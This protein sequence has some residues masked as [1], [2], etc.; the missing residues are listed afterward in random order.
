MNLGMPAKL[1]LAEFEAA[2]TSEFQMDT[3]PEIA[4]GDVPL[5]GAPI[6]STTMLTLTLTQ[7]K[8]K[9]MNSMQEC[10]SL[11]FKAPNDAP[12][13]QALYRLHHPVIGSADIFLVP[14]KKTDEGLFYEAVFN[15][16]IA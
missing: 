10:F 6:G 11:V 3:N 8:V 16:L 2:V 14:F 15:R 7:C 1:E 4:S 12:V 5:C 13:A 9:L